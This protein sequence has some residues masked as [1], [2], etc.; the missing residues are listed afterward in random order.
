[1]IIHRMKQRSPEWYAVRRGKITGT[2]FATVANGR[3]DTIEKLCLRIATERIIG[4]PCDSPYC[5]AAMQNGIETEALAR[6]AYESTTFNRVEEVGFVQSDEWVGVSPDGLVGK[7]G[8]LEI[9]CPRPQTHLSYLMSKEAWLHYKWQVQGSLWVT[10]RD[11][12]DFVS[13]C[14]RF[15]PEQQLVIDRVDRDNEIIN[16]IDEAVRHV[17]ERVMELL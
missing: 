16:T 7:D 5:N 4:V 2:H 17:I 10:G 1:M 8:G 14:P 6:M 3:P 15:P 13:F 9:K 11:W 12:W